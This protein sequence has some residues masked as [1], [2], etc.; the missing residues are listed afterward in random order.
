MHVPLLDLKEHLAP[1]REEILQGITRVVDS[2]CY[3]LGPEVEKFEKRIA[4]YCDASFAIGVAS[5]TDA[6]LASLMALGVKEGDLVLTTPFSFFATM[7]CIVRL[8]ARPVFVDIDPVS[9]N[10]DTEKMA[11]VLAHDAKGDRKIKVI[12]PVHLYGQCAAMTQIM[13]LADQYG[14][15]VLEDAAQAIGATCPVRKDGKTTWYKAGAMG[16]AGCFSFFPS[17][18]LG[19]VGDAGMIVCNDEELADKIKIIRVHGG[20]PKYHHKVIGGNFRIDPIQ[21]VVLDVKLSYLPEWHKKRRTNALLY[22]QLFG[23]T[24]L[25]NTGAVK[26]P[27][28]IYREAAL[29]AGVDTDYHIYNQYVIRVKDRDGLKAFLEKEGITTEIYYPIPLHK[30]E[31]LAGLGYGEQSFPE[32]ENA[33]KETLA[34]PIYPELTDDMQQYVV[35][36]IV[37]YFK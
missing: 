33:A 30:Q 9:Y 7:G 17:K 1:L 28:A 31:C 19:G 6:L 25:L 27:Q 12:L 13:A 18:N 37:A 2:T 8:G 11:E 32:A 26:L 34:L 14:M 24:D 4:A 35:E 3:I 21:A 36:R 22:D 5:G 15:P 29:S 23:K 16:R 20:A 10:I